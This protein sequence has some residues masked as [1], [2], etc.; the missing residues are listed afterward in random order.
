M[1]E[2]VE[3]VV[4]TLTGADGNLK[5]ELQPFDSA[6]G[7]KLF[8]NP[9]H[10]VLVTDYQSPEDPVTDPHATDDEAE[11]K[12]RKNHNLKEAQKFKEELGNME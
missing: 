3:N 9:K 5:A 10:V 8:I 4:D 1:A 7:K 2:N 12:E 11:D 6:G